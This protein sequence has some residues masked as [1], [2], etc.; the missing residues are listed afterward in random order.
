MWC[1]KECFS[2]I[3]GLECTVC[4]AVHF[5]HADS[6]GGRN[7]SCFINYWQSFFKAAVLN[8][9]NHSII[10]IDCLDVSDVKIHLGLIRSC[11]LFQSRIF[12]FTNTLLVMVIYKFPRKIMF[13]KLV[14]CIDGYIKK[15]QRVILIMAMFLKI[16]TATLIKRKLLSTIFE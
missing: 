8:F 3:S 7:W 1:G 15:T 4:T 16:K 5:I 2:V 13:T 10:F 6:H 9:L 11:F 12:I 14:L